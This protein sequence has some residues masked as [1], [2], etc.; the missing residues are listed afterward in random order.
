MSL[1]DRINA[2]PLPFAELLGIEFISRG[3]L[4]QPARRRQGD[5]DDREQ[6]EFR[7][8]RA[9]RLDCDRPYER[10][11]PRQ[12]NPDLADPGRDRR[13]EAGRARRADADEPL[14]PSSAPNKSKENQIKP[15]KKAWISLDSFGR[16]RTFQRV[17]A[18]P[19]K[20]NRSVIVRQNFVRLYSSPHLSLVVPQAATEQSR[21]WLDS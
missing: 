13:R 19:S 7:R 4:Y 12:K 3:G 9:G 20:K 6:D 21:E 18:N 10:R 1:I 8:L 11:S 5:N 2:S 14:T 16:I 15:R 17:T